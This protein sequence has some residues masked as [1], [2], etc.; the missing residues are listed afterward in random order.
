MVIFFSD[1]QF[2]NQ[3]MVRIYL[4]YLHSINKANFS[5]IYYLYSIYSTFPQTWQQ[6][7][8]YCRRMG[9]SLPVITSAAQNEFVSSFTSVS[10]SGFGS[11]FQEYQCAELAK[12]SFFSR[13]S[14]SLF[15]TR[16]CYRLVMVRFYLMPK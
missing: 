7:S 2:I 8:T 13:Y 16:Y 5:D 9:G 1:Y 10:K 14:F 6:A 3:D 4:G 12:K 15:I 11:I